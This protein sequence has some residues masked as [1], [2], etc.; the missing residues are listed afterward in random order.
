MHRYVIFHL[1]SMP[2]S[3][4]EG[5]IRFQNTAETKSSRN[6]HSLCCQRQERIE[7]RMALPGTICAP[8]GQRVCCKQN[9]LHQEQ[10]K[11]PSQDQ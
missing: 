3:T 2:E 7:P 6:P 11:K 5:E 1:G 8:R 4:N 10:E 9:A